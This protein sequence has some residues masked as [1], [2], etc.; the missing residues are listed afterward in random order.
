MAQWL[1][2]LSVLAEVLSSVPSTHMVAHS[3]QELWFQGIQQL[4]LGTP[5][6]V[7]CTQTHRIH[8]QTHKYIQD[9]RE[10]GEGRRKEREGGG[11]EGKQTDRC[12]AHLFNPST[13]EAKAGG[14]S[15]SSRPA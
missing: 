15:L 10:E 4:L 5:V 1:R 6:C 11:K 12:W 2:A 9:G 3:H 14:G 7:W 8:T 13:Q